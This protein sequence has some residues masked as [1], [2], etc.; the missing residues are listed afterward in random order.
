MGNDKDKKPKPPKP[1]KP[2]KEKKIKINAGNSSGVSDFVTVKNQMKIDNKVTGNAF[3]SI[4]KDDIQDKEPFQYISKNGKYISFK[5]IGMRWNNSRNKQVVLKSG[6]D[7]VKLKLKKGNA[8]KNSIITFDSCL[9]KDID[10]K[11]EVTGYEWKKHIVFNKSSTIGKIPN[12]AE[13][14]EISY[15]IKT[16][17]L[18][19]WDKETDMEITG[20]DTY[21]D[22]NNK[23]LSPLVWDSYGSGEEIKSY[24]WKKRGKLYFVKQIPVNFIE[25]AVFPIYTDAEIVVNSTKVEF[26]DPT[27]YDGGIDISDDM[28]PLSICALDNDTGC[29]VYASRTNKYGYL[30]SFKCSVSGDITMHSTTWR[31]DNGLKCGTN[32]GMTVLPL[33]GSNVLIV[34]GSNTGT[35]GV[36][37]S[38][39]GSKNNYTWTFTTPSSGPYSG[40]WHITAGSISGNRFGWRGSWGHERTVQGSG[41]V[42]GTTITWGGYKHYWGDPYYPGHNSLAQMDTNKIVYQN[43]AQGGPLVLYTHEVDDDGNIGSLITGTTFS[44]LLYGPHQGRL[45]PMETDKGLLITR[46]NITDPY[47]I[48]VVTMSGNTPSMVETTKEQGTIAFTGQSNTDNGWIK[49]INDDYFAVSCVNETTHKVVVAVGEFDSDTNTVTMYDPIEAYTMDK[50]YSQSSKCAIMNQ[51]SKPYIHTRPTLVVATSESTTLT[52][53]PARGYL[54]G[55]YIN[56]I[57]DYRQHI[58]GES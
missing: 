37:G 58:F 14:L 3:G 5:P 43:F 12:G 15:E 54:I 22:E 17:F 13:F 6:V 48:Y 2:K 57:D 9:G 29:V 44:F 31:F 1:P 50:I 51:E 21:L 7:K 27:S 16:N 33:S 4:I 40:L 24:L 30:R 36:V 53:S 32:T 55:A 52:D 8:K 34:W 11:I 28:A 38:Y 20:I 56:V 35:T 25:R 45:I 42:H 41:I 19:S 23:I 10:I 39:T 46:H 49:K 26:T 18:M 47:R